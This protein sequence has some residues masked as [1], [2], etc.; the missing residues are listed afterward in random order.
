MTSFQPLFSGSSGNCTLVTSG[1]G[2]LLIDAGVSCRAITGALA[3]TGVSP[4]SLDG[5]LITHEHSDHIKGLAVFTKRYPIPVYGSR[6][7]LEFLAEGGY[8]HP[9]VP[10]VEISSSTQIGGMTVTPFDTSHDSVHSLGFRIETE[11]GY[12]IGIAT[13][14][15]TVTEPVQ[16]GLAGC[17]LVMLESNYDEGMLACSGYPYQLKRRISSRKG[18]LENKACADELAE[19]A[20]G[21]TRRFVLC[22]LSRENNLPE[23]ALQTVYAKME[24]IGLQAAEY[25]IQ[26]ARRDEPSPAVRLGAAESV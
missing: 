26:A 14:L 19:L 2:A 24:E 10:L 13:D 6:Q 23:L 12:S 25:T 21:G 20:K 16:A 22:H 5:I 7:V 1:G 9:G 8:V 18:H 15:G 17:D 3:Q 4:G 11:D